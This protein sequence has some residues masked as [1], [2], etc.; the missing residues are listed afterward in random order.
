MN[1]AHKK[2]Q[3]LLIETR[4]RLNVMLVATMVVLSLGSSSVV[5]EFDEGH[6]TSRAP[7]TKEN[8]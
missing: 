8:V 2:V 1:S 4:I 7:K 5:N 6:F 3:K